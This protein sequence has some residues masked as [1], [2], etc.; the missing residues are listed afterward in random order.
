[1]RVLAHLSKDEA[2][3]KAFREGRDIHTIVAS[4]IFGVALGS[5]SEEE[6]RAAK[7]INFGIVYGI[8]PFGLAKQ[9]NISQ[10]DAKK[11]IDSYFTR[12]SGVKAWIDSIVAFARKNG[13][14]KT[15]LGRIR[16]LP[17]INSSNYQLRSFAERTAMN[18][19]VQGTS[20]DIIKKAMIDIDAL[21][22][23]NSAEDQRSDTPL[24]EF[25]EAVQ[26]FSII[27]QVHDDLLFEVPRNNVSKTAGILKSV[28]ENCIKLDVPLIVDVK[29][30]QNWDE[31]KKL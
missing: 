12:F 5:V 11:Y 30:G 21:G 8:S 24:F 4:D 27:M 14:V 10:N 16:Y 25:A 2:L 1:L 18:T 23:K 6:R 28:M 20:A 15:L 17:E 29:S 22:D 7:S 3:L 13:F 26:E 31:M 19:P 9:L